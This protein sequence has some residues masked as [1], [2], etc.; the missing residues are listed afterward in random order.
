MNN[1]HFPRLLSPLDLGFTALKNRVVMGSM[2]TGLEDVAGGYKKLAVFYRE[3]AR[4]GVGLIITGGV[5]PTFRGRLALSATQLSFRWQLSR[6]QYVT[7]AVHAE[8]AKICM[9]I[10]HAGRYAA[11]PFAVAPSAIRAPISPITPKALSA[12][13]VESTINAFVK[14][15]KL[16]RMAG[17]DGVEIMGSEGYLINQ[18]I[19]IHSNQR[20]DDWGGDFQ[21]R[22]RF[23]LEIVR[24][25]RKAVGSDWILIFRLSMLDLLKQGSSWQEVVMLA[26]QLEKAGVT[27]INTGIGWH[28]V[29]I[30]TI[31]A[32]VPRGAF[33][34]VTAKLKNSVKVPLIT[35]NRI[36]TPELAEDILENNYAD[37][38]S[39]ARPFLA[40][41]EFVSKASQGRSALINT[42]IAC[43]QGCLDHVFKK[44]RA[45][46][47]VNP[48][49]GYETELEYTQ[50]KIPKKIVVV[51]LGPA[52]MSCASI[53]AQRGH[54]VIA[55]DAQQ[56]GGQLNLAV[57]IPG[58]QEFNET[59]RYFS[60]RMTE[61]GVEMHLGNKV[62]ADDLKNS[63][64]DI[65]VIATGVLPRVP[66]IE[67][68]DH[69]KVVLYPDVI[70]GRVSVGNS[71][72]IMGAG[73]IGFD[74]AAL[75][76]HGETNEN[77][78]NQAWGIDTAY[79]HRGGLLPA[80]SPIHAGRKI[81]MLQR[82]KGKMGASLGK[83]TGWIHRL[84]LRNAGV[85]MLSGVAYRHIDDE[86]LHIIQHGKNRILDVDSV[87]I[88]A[89]QQSDHALAKALRSN[90]K[91]VHMIGGALSA[92]DIDAVSAIRQG[93]ELAA[94]L[95]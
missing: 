34:W 31:A 68:I 43:N 75:L 49:A 7:N 63:D 30:P 41:A 19:C 45:T 51:G 92:G 87:V 35:S 79:A 72:A 28:E 64:A 36:N 83:T 58:K 81:M 48:R 85:E 95:G 61:L 32:V 18:F 57:R 11:H 47:L 77:Q 4:G 65:F 88:C 86:G 38:V 89:G 10:L 76:V 3:R 20:H 44:Q 26:Q 84:S 91:Q 12:K 42:C 9:Q 39:M 5:S 24:R 94:K 17:Y 70:S 56:G 14:T 73:G 15:A 71:V 78:W 1:E 74:V 82:S 46:C 27:L 59:M 21:N 2:H 52:G 16:A 13:Q 23:P 6:H 8:G 22:I 66:D 53:A 37:M 55:Y 54:T 50:T 93:A 80:Q 40:D 25:I 67:G 62:C 90:N 29:R 69:N 33:T 60:N